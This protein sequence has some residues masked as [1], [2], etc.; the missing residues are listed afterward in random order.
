M[1]SLENKVIDR[2]YGKGR[3]WCF[4][5]IDFVDLGTRSAIDVAFNSLLKKETISRALRGIYYYPEYSTVL[6]KNITPRIENIAEAIARKYKWDIQPS[7]NTA[8]NYFQLSTQIPA[9]YVYLSDGP[10][11]EYQLDKQLLIFKKT[12]LQE[13]KLKYME[14]KLTVQAIKA[15]GKEQFT[16]EANKKIK[17]HFNS[18]QLQKIKKDTIA[19]T[20]WVRDIIIGIC[21]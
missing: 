16:L 19:I 8:L 1:R 11:K 18:S 6:K 5:Q 14:S 17:S 20:G 15:L 21:S 4:S 9:Q 7:G 10:S 12:K 3:G 2:I 13:A